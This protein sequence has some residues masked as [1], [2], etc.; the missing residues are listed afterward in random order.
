MSSSSVRD[1]ARAVSDEEA[2]D[3]DGS[4]EGSDESSDESSE[5][6]DGDKDKDRNNA[7]NS[8]PTATTPQPPSASLTPRVRGKQDG[9]ETWSCIYCEMRGSRASKVARSRKSVD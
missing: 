2:S 8:A 7:G 5:D 1:S 9:R 4:D 6:E 3:E